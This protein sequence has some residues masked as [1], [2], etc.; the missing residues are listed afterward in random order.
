MILF[1]FQ[2]ILSEISF[3]DLPSQYRSKWRNIYSTAEQSALFF[4]YIEQDKYLRAHKGQYAE[5]NGA[6]APWR[7]Q[8][9]IKI[10]QDLFMNV[11]KT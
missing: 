10:I 6:Q 5:R 11:G 9:D 3:A 2:K 4:K 1:I 8:V 7:N